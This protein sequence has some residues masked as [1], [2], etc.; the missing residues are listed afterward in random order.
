MFRSENYTKLVLAHE[1]RFQQVTE[2]MA[3]DLESLSKILEEKQANIMHPSIPPRGFTQEHA[4]IRE[5][6]LRGFACA[7]LN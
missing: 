6:T 1:K 7:F 2:R 5:K 4:S 3:R